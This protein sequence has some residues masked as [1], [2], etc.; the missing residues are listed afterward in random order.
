M[1]IFSRMICY[2]NSKIIGCVFRVQFKIVSVQISLSDRLFKL[3]QFWRPF[4][5]ILK[6]IHPGPM[7]IFVHCWPAEQYMVEQRIQ[8][9]Q[10]VWIYQ[11]SW[12]EANRL[13]ERGCLGIEFLYLCCKVLVKLV[14]VEIS[15]ALPVWCGNQC[16]HG[17]HVRRWHVQMLG[18]N[19][20]K[21]VSCLVDGAFVD[22]EC[23]SVKMAL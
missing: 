12:I 21:T 9:K 22:V 2:K 5:L 8:P 11:H 10:V 7:S 14:V 23:N 17:I 16:Q 6:Q 3:F 20:L 4:F 15:S 13:C 19:C 18:F 1:V